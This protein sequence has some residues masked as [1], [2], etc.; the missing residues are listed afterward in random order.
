[1]YILCFFCALYPNLLKAMPVG[2]FMVKMYSS[3]IHFQ[4]T[5]LMNQYPSAFSEAIF[6]KCLKKDILGSKHTFHKT[7]NYM[8]EKGIVLNPSVLI[9]NHTNYI[10]RF[11]LLK[12]EDEKKAQNYLIEKYKDCIDVIFTFSSL[13]S[14]FLY[15]YAHKELHRLQGDIMLED[16]VA[17]LRTVFP[18][19]EHEKYENRIL[20]QFVLNP[21]Y[22][23]HEPLLWDEKMWEIYYW[24]KINYRLYNSE[25]AK[26]IGLDPVTVARRKKKMLPSLHIYYPVFAEDYNDY[27]M[28]LFVLKDNVDSVVQ[29][30]SDLSATSYL[31]KGVKGTYLCFAPTRRP[32]VLAPKM[33]KIMDNESL[34]VVHLSSRWTPVLEDY[35]K[36]KVEERFFRMFSPHSK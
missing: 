4:I 24:L 21:H 35:Q 7:L 10:N 1:M 13:E 34:G 8:E 22:T 20:P 14:A 27:S 5:R 6:R 19:K 26:K 16:T 15:V 9:K 11:Y 25:I 29:L 33:R 3:R 31:L 28:L 23:R 18:C 12:V 32:H 30:L 17:E 36:G 2:L